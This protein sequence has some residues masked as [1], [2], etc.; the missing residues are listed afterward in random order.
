QYSIIYKLLED[1]ELALK[2]MPEPVYAPRT[3]GTA[4]VRQVFR[5]SRSGTIA[6]SVIREGA[7][8]RNARARA[9]RGGS[10]IHEES[11]IAS[12][13]RFN[14]DVREGRTGFE[15]G[16]GLA[17]FHDFEV[18]DLGEFFVMERVS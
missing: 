11:S 3:I 10:V 5:I 12:I 9:K 14:V 13:N 16:I 6:G 15:C 1:V 4:G 2:G 17:D 8:R 7:A 18:G